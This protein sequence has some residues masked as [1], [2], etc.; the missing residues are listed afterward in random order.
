MNSTAATPCSDGAWPP[1]IRICPCQ[2]RDLLFSGAARRRASD[3]ADGCFDLGV[4]YALHFEGDGFTLK[5]DFISPLPPDDLKRLSCPVCYTE[6]EAVFDGEVPADF[7]VALALDEEY[8]YNNERAQV[9]GGVL[10]LKGYEAAFMTRL[11]NLVMSN[12][13]DIAAPDWGDT[14]LAGRRASL[15]RTPRSTSISRREGQS[16][17][18]K[19]ASGA[20]SSPSA[21]P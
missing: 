17:C 12:A 7:S 18:A 14:Y 16:T 15:L 3:E 19:S 9:V 11:R 4:R 5:V 10:P 13:D 6:Y 21:A 20:T 8:C 2:R 1:Y